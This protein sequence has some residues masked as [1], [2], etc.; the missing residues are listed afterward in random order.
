[1]LCKNNWIDIT[2]DG[3]ANRTLK[4]NLKIDF[5]ARA[6]SMLPFDK[7]CDL[8]AQDIYSQHKKL[9]LALSGGCD[10]E[11][12]AN[13]LVRNKIP[14]TPIVAVYNHVQTPSEKLESWHAIEWCKLNK[15]AP[16][17]LNSQ[18]YIG[19]NF[20]KQCFS[21]IKPRLP[22]GAVT[23]GMLLATVQNLDG[24]LLTGAQLEY[25]PDSEQMT[26]LEPQ[27]GNYVGF[28]MEE[29]DLYLE[30]LSPNIHPWAFY[31]WNPEILAAFINEW[32]LQA[33]MQQNKSKIYK[34]PYR[35]KY[36]Y[37][38]DFIPQSNLILRNTLKA[39]FGTIDCALLGTKQYLLDKIV[40]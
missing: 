37:C 24:Q 12:I 6:S 34:V 35:K 40:K 7:A 13:V 25:Y 2:W 31:Y 29:S 1:M 9:F 11:N 20:D 5:H 19:S 10:S 39:N 18:T 17:I 38:D 28:V 22:N 14:F 21:T 33:T 30:T 36:L 15:I 4:E 27:L 16:I 26:Y 8:V 32:D 23:T 3:A